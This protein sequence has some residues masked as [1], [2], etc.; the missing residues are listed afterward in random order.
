MKRLV[1]VFGS[2]VVAGLIMLTTAAPA[3]I[4]VEQRKELNQ[5]RDDIGDVAKLIREKKYEDAGKM[6]DDFTAKLEKIAKDADLK[7]GDK[8]LAPVQLLIDKQKQALQKAGGIGAGKADA[9][10]VS[11]IKEI[12]PLLN[13]K[14]VSCHGDNAAGRLRLDSFAEMKKGG[15]SGPLLS[16][17]NPRTS[18][19]MTRVSAPNP[20]LRMPKDAAALTN[21]ELNLLANWIKQGAKF[22]SDD[23]NL[24]LSEFAKPATKA[25]TNTPIKITKATGN[26]K[27]KFIKDLAPDFVEICERCHSGNNPRGGFRTVTFEDLMRGG[28]SGAVL[29]PGDLEGSRL[30][31]LINGGPP[32]MPPGQARIYRGWYNN[33]KIWI[34][35]GCKYDG[36]DPKVPLRRYVPTEEELKLATLAKMTADEFLTMRKD[37]TREQWKKVLSKEEATELETSDFFFYGNVDEGRMK[38][39]SAWADEHAK[40]LRGAF[41]LPDSLIWRGKLAVLVYKDRFGYAEFNQTIENRD[42]D[43]AIFGHSEIGVGQEQAYIVL[44]DVGDTANSINPDT[45]LNLIDQMTGA[46][47]KRDGKKLP[48]WLIRGTGL[49]MATKEVGGDNEY[50][51]SLR[52]SA[53]DALRGIEQPGDLFADGKFA[54]TDMAP[55]GFTL[56]SFMIKEGSQPKFGQF[57]TALQ[58]GKNLRDAVNDV[59]K[60]ATTQTLA[61]AY[62]GSLGQS[63]GPA[64][65]KK[66]KK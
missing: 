18:L 58:S 20:A 38:Q 46:F 64:V 19:I 27:V 5:I 59:Y 57:L 48:E 1:A 35:E 26:E 24:K 55:I 52:A 8:T 50:L 2:L 23:E 60:P 25:R 11:F 7:P 9:A 10:D 30:W 17:G 40:A 21:D 54:P 61:T 15:K 14:C 34:E 39:L 28:D 36:D 6:L 13:S 16:I 32:K 45:R 22:D 29:K 65:K 41:K 49:A 37:Q 31:E 4:T 62:L 44:Q 3:A 51:R 33:L 56:V 42:A 66:G 63:T 12:A 47:L 53:I 43:P